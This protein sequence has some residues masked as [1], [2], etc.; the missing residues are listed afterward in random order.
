MI[1]KLK[2]NFQNIMVI[3]L[4]LSVLLVPSL[5]ISLAQTDEQ[6]KTSSGSG[7]EIKMSKAPAQYEIFEGVPAQFEGK[8]KDSSANVA[9]YEWNIVSGKGGKLENEK[10]LKVT[11]IASQIEGE[12]ELFALELT[13]DYK[14]GEPGKARINILVHKRPADIKQEIK[15]QVVKKKKVEYRSSPWLAG[16][17][18]FGLGYI[19]SYPIY[20]PIIIPCPGCDIFPPDI[21]LIE[22]IPIPHEDLDSLGLEAF[23]YTA[24]SLDMESLEYEAVGVDEAIEPYQDVSIEPHDIPEQEPTVE[25]PMEM[26]MDEPMDYGDMDYGDMDYGGDW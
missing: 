14:T 23:E 3:V 6:Q 7:D 21:D 11:F 1:N 18:G 16:T 22:P 25:Q 12:K 10:T 20:A 4:T 13:T 5:Q 8:A 17:I 9:G 24:E 26:P 2:T 19:W 15:Q